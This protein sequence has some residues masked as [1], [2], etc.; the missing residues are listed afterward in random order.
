MG[1][2][3]ARSTDRSTAMFTDR[4][5]AEPTQVEE[6]VEPRPAEGRTTSWG[7][8]KTTFRRQPPEDESVPSRIF[9]RTTAASMFLYGRSVVETALVHSHRKLYKLYLYA[10]ENRTERVGPQDALIR[11]LAERKGIKIIEVNNRALR[12]MDKVSEGRPHN[13]WIL[14]ASPV[15]QLPLKSLGPLS[16][17]KCGYKLVQSHQAPEDKQINGDYDF[18]PYQ[19]AAGRHPFILL[20]DGIVDPGNLGAIIRSAA[21]LGVNAVAITRGHSSPITPATIKASAGA[22]ELIKLFSVPSSIDFL[23]RSKES[24]W[25][26][27]AAVPPRLSRSR[28]NSHLTLDLL[29]AY[30]PLS[31]QPTIL[32]LGSEGDGLSK[33]VR[34]AADYEVSIS[35]Q[36]F[37]SFVDSLNVSVAAALLCS[38]FLKK[39]FPGFRIDKLTQ[40]EGKEENNEGNED[41][42]DRLW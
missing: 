20:L 21:F 26:V 33:Q 36:S 4:P 16:D 29:E 40:A 37:Q 1:G 22:S 9:A 11:A 41:G 15:P 34:R 3:P 12:E 5:P 17:D 23:T 39:Q 18:V 24:G 30:D 6:G 13:G 35:N 10:G 2:S 42:E 14:E 7:D 27:F 8:G 25:A 28:G 31:A 38:S 32:V 19:L